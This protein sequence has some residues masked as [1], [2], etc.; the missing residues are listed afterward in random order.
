LIERGIGVDVVPEG[1]CGV[2][3]AGGLEV[4]A[5]RGITTILVEGGARLATSLLA[6]RRVHRAIVAIAPTVLGEGTN[7]IGDLGVGRISEA[8]HLQ[9]SLA[10]MVGHDI[11]MA[12]DVEP[13]ER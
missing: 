9:H 4:L 11:V 1:P 8:I 2:S 6:E 13:L 7:A 10:R 3:L 5:A 12:G